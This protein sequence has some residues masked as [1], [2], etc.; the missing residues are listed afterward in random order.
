MHGRVLVV[1]DEQSMCELLA[2]GLTRRGFSV[3]W[4]LGGEEA[5]ETLAGEDFDCLITDIT[6]RGLDGIKL[7]ARVTGTRPDIPVIVITAFGSLATAIAAI[8]AGAYDFITKPFDIEEVALSLARAIQYRRLREEVRRLRQ[9]VESTQGFA[10]LVGDSRAMKA[11]YDLVGRVADTDTSVLILGET[12]TGK[13]LVARTLHRRSRRRDGPFVAFGCGAVPESLVESE[14]FG[15]CKGSFTDAKSDRTGLLLQADGGTL[16]LDEIGDMPGAFQAK[17]LRV[18]QERRV[19]P[20]G[21]DAEIPFDVRIVAAT[22]RDLEAAVEENRFRQDLLFR[23]NVITVELPPLRARGNDVLLLAQRFLKVFADRM[24]KAVTGIAPATAAKL[25]GYAWPG[26]VRE[27]QNCIERAVALTEYDQITVE[28]LPEK[29]RDYR[30]SHVIVAGDDP[31]ELP[32]LEEV[33][34]RYIARVLE[35]V[36]DNKSLAAR[37][38]GLDRTTLYRRLARGD[39]P[40]GPVASAP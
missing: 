38:L 36:N 23:V 15:F 21:G 17:L 40:E 12:G 14:L 31:D 3:T 25:L 34:R 18:L 29:I 19:R 22:N 2:D 28:D 30:S 8:R 4:R 9:S 7:C 10:E 6:M 11:V 24:G 27:L 35:A 26:N 39:Q 33:Q 16:F 1:D 37:I 20:L 5:L 13:E 32:T